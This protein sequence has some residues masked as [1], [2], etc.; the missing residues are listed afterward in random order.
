MVP[1]TLVSRPEF[2]T[3]HQYSI[4]HYSVRVE[5]DTLAEVFQYDLVRCID[6]GGVSRGPLIPA[7]QQYMLECVRGVLVL[8]DV[9][10]SVPLDC[11]GV[12]TAAPCMSKL[13]MPLSLPLVG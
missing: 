7:V 5:L 13:T 1:A 6:V 4:K 3:I 12:V 8:D 10:L 2:H 9:A 11:D